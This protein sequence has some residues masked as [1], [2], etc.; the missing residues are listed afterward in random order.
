M[1]DTYTSVAKHLRDPV[2]HTA[3]Q[4]SDLMCGGTRFHERR[5]GVCRC[6]TDLDLSSAL[7][8]TP[9]N[10]VLLQGTIE[11]RV[12]LR[13]P[14]DYRLQDIGMEWTDNARSDEHGCVLQR[15][16]HLFP[17]MVDVGAV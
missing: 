1:V 11:P 7:T 8:S 3:P 13:T 10:R 14:T 2:L 17:S 5:M 16:D 15:H 9:E 6:E 12:Q 4:K